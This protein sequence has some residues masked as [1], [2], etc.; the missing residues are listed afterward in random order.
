MGGGL[1]QLVASGIQD[2]ILI[3]NPQI[4]YFKK[5]FK[6]YTNFALDQQL[7]NF[8]GPVNFGNK[9]TCILRKNGDLLGRL[10]L[11]VKL[12]EIL[13]K[14]SETSTE[15]I[16]DIFKEC[17]IIITEDDLIVSTEVI[18]GCIEE[19][20]ENISNLFMDIDTLEQ[21]ES[22][23]NVEID[24]LYSKLVGLNSGNECY[25]EFMDDKFE[26]IRENLERV[27]CVVFDESGNCVERQENELILFSG[28]KKEL[29]YLC[30]ISVTL[31]HK[32]RIKI[33]N[34]SLESVCECIQT[35]Q[36]DLCIII[37]RY[38]DTELIDGTFLEQVLIE[39]DLLK[40][41]IKN[42]ILQD[43]PLQ[44]YIDEQIVLL[45]EDIN[46][47]F[48]TIDENVDEYIIPVCE[49]Q[50]DILSD[51]INDSFSGSLAQIDSFVDFSCFD[52]N[53]LRVGPAMDPQE[54]RQNIRDDIN[55]AKDVA[56]DD[57]CNILL[58]C[59]FNNIDVLEE[60]LC[61]V[62]LDFN[63]ATK[64]AYVDELN[65]RLELDASD[66]SYIEKLDS[67]EVEECILNEEIDDI[68]NEIKDC[69]N[70]RKLT[71]TNICGEISNILEVFK[72]NL[73]EFNDTYPELIKAA[74]QIIID[75]ICR[76]NKDL[77][78]TKL[79][80]SQIE[81]LC[82]QLCP[83]ETDECEQECD[84]D[85]LYN[86]SFKV[87]TQC[88]RNIEKI[89]CFLL[90]LL[91][92]L[93]DNEDVDP[94][95]QDEFGND[96]GDEKLTNLEELFLRIECQLFTYIYRRNVINDLIAKEDNND[97]LP[98]K[99]PYPA[100]KTDKVYNQIRNIKDAIIVEEEFL[101]EK[102]IC[103]DPL[104]QLTKEEVCQAEKDEL[105]SKI[106]ES[107][108]FYA[109]DEEFF[110]EPDELDPEVDLPTEVC[111]SDD[112]G[113]PPIVYKCYY[114]S[115]GNVYCTKPS[116]TDVINTLLD[117]NNYV[118]L[119]CF[120]DGSGNEIQVP[121][122][123]SSG[124]APDLTI[125]VNIEAAVNKAVDGLCSIVD[126][127][128]ILN[129]V[130]IEEQI[131]NIINQLPI[132][133]INAYVEEFERRLNL[134]SSD[135]EYI[136]L[137]DPYAN[138]EDCVIG[139]DEVIECISELE[140]IRDKVF[141]YKAKK[142]GENVNICTYP[143]DELIII[144]YQE[145]GVVEQDAYDKT[146]LGQ[147]S[148]LLGLS[149][150]YDC[151][152]RINEKYEA[153][154]LS[155]ISCDK[156][157]DVEYEKRNNFE[158]YM[159][160]QLCGCI[161]SCEKYV[162]NI[163]SEFDPPGY[164]YGV[165]KVGDDIGIFRGDEFDKDC[166]G[167]TFVDLSGSII[168]L[169][170]LC[171]TSKNEGFDDTNI[172][173]QCILREINKIYNPLP[174]F[175]KENSYKS[176]YYFA[177]TIRILLDP[178]NTVNV[179]APVVKYVNRNLETYYNKS[180]NNTGYYCNLEGYIAIK[181]TLD[182]DFDN[183]YEGK[184]A[185]YL[186]L[187][188]IGLNY[189]FS[190]SYNIM[191][192]LCCD[193]LFTDQRY[194]K[195]SENRCFFIGY[196]P[197]EI[198]DIGTIE[199][200]DFDKIIN[201]EYN[202]NQSVDFDDSWTKFMATLND[203]RSL[204]DIQN[205]V[206]ITD[207]DLSKLLD[208]LENTNNLL[209]KF[210]KDEWEKV[211]T[212]ISLEY[213]R[214]INKYVGLED[215]QVNEQK[216]LLL[217][218]D[219]NGINIFIDGSGDLVDSC[220]NITE[221]LDIN[222]LP[223]D[224]LDDDGLLIANLRWE[225]IR[226]DANL[227]CYYVNWIYLQ[228]NDIVYNWAKNYVNCVIDYT[229]GNV[230]PPSEET[231]VLGIINDFCI[232]LD[233][234]HTNMRDIILN[235]FTNPVLRDPSY[236]KNDTGIN[237]VHF[238]YEYA[239]NTGNSV[240]GIGCGRFN[241][242]T[243]L[244]FYI[245]NIFI[246]N[247]NN[248]GNEFLDATNDNI[249]AGIINH[250]IDHYNFI[251]DFKADKC[252][253]ET[254]TNRVKK[255]KLVP[256]DS[257]SEN[258]DYT[259]PPNYICNLPQEEIDRLYEEC[260]IE[261]DA[262]YNDLTEVEIECLREA[263]LKS[264]YD[265]DCTAY[266][267]FETECLYDDAFVKFYGK[268][269]SDIQLRNN[270]GIEIYTAFKTIKYCLFGEQYDCLVS[271]LLD[272]RDCDIIIE[273][274][275]FKPSYMD[276][277]KEDIIGAID[278]IGLLK[279]RHE[280]NLI[281][282]DVQRG[283]SDCLKNAIVN[284][285]QCTF[286]NRD[287]L[288]DILDGLV[289]D[290]YTNPTTG[291]IKDT[292]ND[293]L[294]S[295]ATSKFSIDCLEWNTD[296]CEIIIFVLSCELNRYTTFED[297]FGYKPLT[298]QE[299]NEDGKLVFVDPDDET[300]EVIKCP[301]ESNNDKDVPGY[302][303]SYYFLDDLDEENKICET[304]FGSGILRKNAICG[305][306]EEPVE[307][308]INF[309]C[310]IGVDLFP[311]YLDIIDGERFIK[312]DDGLFYKV[313][314]METLDNQPV[315][316]Y[317]FDE[318]EV[319]ILHVDENCVEDGL[320]DSQNEDLY[321]LKQQIT[322]ETRAPLFTYYNPDDLN[323]SDNG[324]TVRLVDFNNSNNPVAY[325]FETEPSLFAKDIADLKEQ[326]KC[327]LI[328]SDIPSQSDITSVEC[329]KEL[330]DPEY[331]EDPIET[332]I[333]DEYK[334]LNRYCCK[335][336]I[337]GN[338]FSGGL[339]IFEDASANL[340]YMS[341]YND[342]DNSP[343]ATYW[344]TDTKDNE[345]T[346]INIIQQLKPVCDENGTPEDSVI[347]E[348]RKLN[349]GSGNDATMIYYS[350]N[351]G[352]TI[353]ETGGQYDVIGGTVYYYIYID[354]KLFLSDVPYDLAEYYYNNDP[355]YAGNLFKLFLPTV[356]L[357]DGGSIGPIPIAG[358]DPSGVMYEDCGY[359]NYS[360]NDRILWLPYHEATISIIPDPVTYG[361]YKGLV[362][363]PSSC[364]IDPC[365]LPRPVLLPLIDPDPNAPENRVYVVPPLNTASG[366]PQ[367]DIYRVMH[368]KEGTDTFSVST[369]PYPLP[370]E[371]FLEPLNYPYTSECGLTPSFTPEPVSPTP[372]G[373]PY[374]YAYNKD[375][376]GNSINNIIDLIECGVKAKTSKR[377]GVH[378]TFKGNFL[379][380]ADNIGGA[381]NFP[382]HNLLDENGN[383]R[384]LVEYLCEYL[385][386]QQSFEYYRKDP[387]E[388]LPKIS[389]TGKTFTLGDKDGIS[390]L[391]RQ[392]Y[393]ECIE[394]F[395][396]LFCDKI[397]AKEFPLEYKDIKK[398]SDF[399]KIIMDFVIDQTE[400]ADIFDDRADPEGT[401][402]EEKNYILG[403]FNTIIDETEQNIVR[404]KTKLDED[405]KLFC[406]NTLCGNFAWIRRLGHFL[407]DEVSIE[408][409]GQIMDRHYGTWLHIWYELTK[410]VN[411]LRGYDKM[412]GDVPELYTYNNEVK[413]EYIM[414]IPMQ[415]WFC[416]ESG[417]FLPMIGLQYNTV[418][419]DVKF[420]SLD[421]CAYWEKNTRFVKRIDASRKL[422]ETLEDDGNELLYFDKKPELECKVLAEYVYLDKKERHRFAQSRHEYL[423]EQVVRNKS[424][425]V[426]RNQHEI[427]MHFPGPVKEFIWFVQLDKFINGSLPNGELQWYNFTTE[428]Y[429]YDSNEHM[430]RSIE[431][432]RK[433]L[434]VE[435]A[436]G[437]KLAYYYNEYSNRANTN[438]GS[439]KSVVDKSLITLNGKRVTQFYNQNYY[440][441][442]QGYLYHTHTPP[443]GIN[444]FSYALHPEMFQPTGATN[445]GK[446]D[447]STLK[448]QL[449]DSIEIE[450]DIDF[451]P[452]REGDI[453]TK[454]N[455]GKLSIFGTTQNILRILS[456]M[457][458][459]AFDY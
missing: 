237:K 78:C 383:R 34:M 74:V 357:V 123:D 377:E 193:N 246:K 454:E 85:E 218:I 321:I 45:I 25:I 15:R 306:L 43:I 415:F 447:D 286:S 290:K 332:D 57:I 214:I 428:P 94:L 400:Y 159:V 238:F 419:L 421:K 427:Q 392:L 173:D 339:L 42:C 216:Q 21:L 81:S 320:A 99:V 305:I 69:I 292:F 311:V 36:S 35:L 102:V 17:G 291:L 137:V 30:G 52:I 425:T 404:L 456:G 11:Q 82:D 344:D 186:N 124:I 248:L 374:Y 202:K 64:D 310:K 131:N 192:T 371:Y 382:E 457:S 281:I 120:V 268:L 77:N 140:T 418:K 96:V 61:Q 18:C 132:D 251:V 83:P 206:P 41:N 331:P 389:E 385:I 162:I 176:N 134:D 388:L 62:I 359:S 338:I 235:L 32:Q 334:G 368:Y 153:E 295:M 184:Q 95:L 22:D 405:V 24:N 424:L 416:R 256:V 207:E 390:Q 165:L 174:Y 149:D 2:S 348:F 125:V 451:Y 449:D 288:K 190:S 31:T 58:D 71:N 180:K 445:M 169:I 452:C 119:D 361:E 398:K 113:P 328:V 19:T 441:N 175:S 121:Y 151:N 300:I 231:D 212:N 378:A 304:R 307:L 363:D 265:N 308:L 10:Y 387:C 204:E 223:V 437:D 407:I 309:Y 126:N 219:S 278:N 346:D 88:D 98:S 372:P 289:R 373:P 446:I 130:E 277:L 105:F 458:G 375:Q 141:T 87:L 459:L 16:V 340:V 107:F 203:L 49:E 160:K 391:F 324:R 297:Y 254:L 112:P 384:I 358:I 1:L 135:N 448:I 386:L 433:E 51:K 247:S 241:S 280:M 208:E 145:E 453:I 117:Y 142:D 201:F 191:K 259:F 343:G 26:T 228:V 60:E 139:I 182:I 299:I 439:L 104:E 59:S 367:N 122:F 329:P 163:K 146:D 365:P 242:F 213:F 114:D 224:I 260:E 188:T 252:E 245:R 395:D 426:N 67:R 5:V 442:L 376:S 101:F 353:D 225:Y 287:I 330:V 303:V 276:L 156:K 366:V 128:N 243:I 345:I 323:D 302:H 396:K 100:M 211:V 236:V 75:E 450:E 244:D 409:G 33:M 222:G 196:T 110:T 230:D 342:S 337:T 394:F 275:I 274:E 200:V 317:R 284:N 167:G 234:L 354:N 438:H 76:L 283:W 127:C 455:W 430:N 7:L 397:V 210:I 298:D 258:F 356:E 239:L 199:N 116:E 183:D 233:N 185:E 20:C 215:G 93:L 279:E 143:E 435:D 429:E 315:N 56:I 318:N 355:V 440:G 27:F 360:S 272:K 115:C 352:G 179:S 195:D 181:D 138:L 8:T 347:V 70:M 89:Y 79:I 68:T 118:D 194:N 250:V 3:H 72:N 364:V 37:E 255:E 172:G 327:E 220:G 381:T 6:R 198:E 282:Y 350:I 301:D 335:Q 316:S 154:I 54:S 408:I 403:K 266:M 50:K 197:T 205:N 217:P 271:D 53:S 136:E 411:K 296:I 399:V 106:K 434:I 14:Y 443:T 267:I 432:E 92:D 379:Y 170:N 351:V 240:D 270:V 103:S 46:E 401:F 80:L 44:E 261:M 431:R 249:K 39:I 226:V 133:I 152:R 257:P 23:V 90:R 168:E 111:V 262:S 4:T 29:D 164:E 410:D 336:S 157:F 63:Q 86:Q 413:P 406:D 319:F 97:T 148:I 362:Y 178:R 412:I 312:K 393:P 326:L 189:A 370:F 273:P 158:I 161:I 253:C 402:E 313:S 264:I 144:I 436:S 177:E 40:D 209:Y 147:S 380:Y 65:R 229:T 155:R 47:L 166:S 13:L 9:G 349:D 73:V 28:I 444:I 422:G 109:T 66:N 91:E 285:V 423:I 84:I 294:N 417:L 232:C 108:V 48:N 171:G 314:P 322:D 38:T 325:L 420:R 369:L 263:R 187:I 129:G 414:N 150:I 55:L 12:P 269:L 333:Q 227:L 293:Y 221:I 341:L